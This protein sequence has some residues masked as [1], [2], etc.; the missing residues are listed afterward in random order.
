MDLFV[1]IDRG[2]IHYGLSAGFGRWPFD[3]EHERPTL[4]L[5]TRHGDQTIALARYGT[6][7]GGWRKRW[8]AGE[9]HWVYKESPVG[10]RVWA[11][12]ESAPVWKPPQ[13]TLPRA[14]VRE[15][16]DP[17]TGAK[18][19]EIDRNL[20]GPRTRPR[21]GWSQR[22]TAAFGCEK[23][24]SSSSVATRASAAMER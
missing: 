9:D 13:R 15:R 11:H 1:E 8:I 17:A 7:I 5:F 19:F 23:A 6:T 24:A 18:H 22:F 3:D 10:R 12:L 4:T 21:T 20:V 16:L 2:D 14:L